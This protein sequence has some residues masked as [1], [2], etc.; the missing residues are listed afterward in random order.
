MSRDRARAVASTAATVMGLY[1]LYIREG[2]QEDEAT[3]SAVAA[4]TNLRNEHDKDAAEDALL[5]AT[6][7]LRFTHRTPSPWIALLR[8]RIEVTDE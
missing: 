7:R 1:R 8:Q 6:I 5:H 3:E 4:L 2:D